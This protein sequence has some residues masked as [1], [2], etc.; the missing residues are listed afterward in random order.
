MAYQ[1][2]SC[3]HP[4]NSDILGRSGGRTHIRM[5]YCNVAGTGMALYADGSSGRL[6]AVRW[7][8]A[9]VL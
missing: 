1:K 2:M 3:Y 4:P 6:S 8:I 9:G 7:R 5:P